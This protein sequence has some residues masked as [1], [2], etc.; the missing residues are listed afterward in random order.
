MRS[1]DEIRDSGLYGNVRL[2]LLSGC[3]PTRKEYAINEALLIDRRG[4]S[5]IGSTAPTLRFNICKTKTPVCA[6]AWGTNASPRRIAVPFDQRAR[7]DFQ[8]P[9]GHSITPP[10]F[11][12]PRSPA[13]ASLMVGRCRNTPSERRAATGYQPAR[14]PRKR[15]LPRPAGYPDNLSAPDTAI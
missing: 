7:E 6:A 10:S 13:S 12:E 4:C 9:S 2:V 15:D 14:G 8:L 1:Q 5:K 3:G 11:G